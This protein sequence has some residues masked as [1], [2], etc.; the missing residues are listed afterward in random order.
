MDVMNDLASALKARLPGIHLRT[1]EETRAIEA[2]RQTIALI[3]GQLVPR[4]LWR[5]SSAS[6]LWRVSLEESEGDRML[7]DPCGFEEAMGAFKKS[8]ENVVLALLDPWDELARPVFLRY[9]REALA[10]AR[11]TG[12]ALILVG[13][14][15]AIPPEVQADV[16]LCDLRLPKRSELEEYIRSLTVLYS[17]KLAGK[18]KIDDDAIPELAGACTGLSLDAT[19]SIVALSLFRYR[20]IGPES[21]KMAIREKKQVVRRGGVLEYE[22]ITHGM[23]DVGGL[24]TLKSWLSKRSKLFTD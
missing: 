10:H 11:G 4:V 5:W 21:I 23:G 20:A 13:R 2:L 9:L 18:V 19:K 16:F 1:L 17:E 14:D 7:Q 8:E 15:W 24:A 22:E 12:K 6:G 3:S